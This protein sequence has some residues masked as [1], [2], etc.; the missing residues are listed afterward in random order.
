MKG[1]SF[2][3]ENIDFSDFNRLNDCFGTSS[4]FQSISPKV[5][6]PQTLVES[7]QFYSEFLE[8]YYN[9]SLSIIIQNFNL[10]SFD[11]LNR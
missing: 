6:F 7:F 11:D 5:S 9:Q 10:I 2:Y 8:A 3:F 4:L 1:Y